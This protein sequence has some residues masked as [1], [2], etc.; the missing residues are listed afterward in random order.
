MSADR[1]TIRLILLWSVL[2]I[3]PK[4]SDI[5]DSRVYGAL[6]EGS[7]QIL[8]RRV[9]TMNED[10]RLRWFEEKIAISRLTSDRRSLVPKIFGHFRQ[11]CTLFSDLSETK[12]MLTGA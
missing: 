1:V 2:L 8:G 5:C 3:Q 9:S 6:L 10:L 11:A 4:S 7:K 12:A